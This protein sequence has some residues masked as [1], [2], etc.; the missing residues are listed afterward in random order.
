[1]NFVALKMLVG[2][3]L[4]YL[5][6]IAGVSFAALLITQQASIFAGYTLRTGSWIRE[7]TAGG[8]DLWVMDPQVEFSEG[9]KPLADT[10]LQRVRG[11]S[12]VAWAA[13]LYKGWLECRLPDGSKKR[14]RLIGID[15]ATLA[16]GPAEMVEGKL[17]DLRRDRAVIINVDDASSILAL[18]RAGG[19]PLKVGDR[20]DVNDNESVVVGTY[21]ASKEFFWEPV[22][23]TTYT[24]ALTM[25]PRQRR[26]L[27]YVLV[28]VAPGAD[29]NEVARGIK[30]A[31]GLDAH[32][33]REFEWITADYVLKKTGI[34]INFGMTIGLGFVIGLLVAGQTFYTFILD[35][36]RHF[37][38]LKAMGAGNLTVLKMMCLQ[39]LVVGFI[40]YGIGVGG[41]SLTGAAFRSIGLAF[42]MHWL[43]P[44]LGGAAV[45]LCCLASGGPG[46]LRV[47]KLEP[48]VVFKG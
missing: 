16:A 12:G 23:Y 20:L 37:A 9:P 42:Q 30:N 6:L 32:T 15:D 21:R 14:V 46:M 22:V 7:T 44:L 36:L 33:G 4:K 25:A 43:I 18:D 35:N 19:R 47:L 39:V 40:G 31:T 28:K 11:V 3:R 29:V 1:M 45:V 10:A 41:A 13:P 8:A 26:L 24:R 48:S 27:S 2:D 17:A 5:A 34:L 38:A